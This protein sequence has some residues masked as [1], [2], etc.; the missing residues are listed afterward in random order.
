MM[1]VCVV[2]DVLFQ[3][4]M[5]AAEQP[6]EDIQPAENII[7]GVNTQICDP[8]YK[9][10]QMGELSHFGRDRLN[11]QDISH[12]V[13]WLSQLMDLVCMRQILFCTAVQDMIYANDQGGRK[14]SKEQTLPVV[15]NS[16]YS[17]GDWI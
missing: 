9:T 15:L 10:R 16:C 8:S 7:N 4:L 17:K 1:T 2:Y 6:A 3:R 5:E 12:L 13:E 11:L 14:G